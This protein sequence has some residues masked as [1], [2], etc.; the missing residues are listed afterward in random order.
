MA[1]T[2]PFPDIRGEVVLRRLLE[3]TIADAVKRARVDMPSGEAAKYC[4]ECGDEI[5]E[6]RRRVLPATRI[7][8]VCQSARDADRTNVGINRHGSKYSQLR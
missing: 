1:E 2:G 7:C 4:A 6:A 8:V 5:P 3:D